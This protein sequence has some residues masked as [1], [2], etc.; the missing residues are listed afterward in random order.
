MYAFEQQ[1]QLSFFYQLR[2]L[3]AT[4]DKDK[5][6]EFEED[7]KFDVNEWYKWWTDETKN[8]QRKKVTVK[9]LK[10]RRNMIRQA[11]VL[12]KMIR[13]MCLFIVTRRVWIALITMM[14]T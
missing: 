8:W 3:R 7:E 4:N 1:F 5:A 10:M 13:L 6:N 9:S 2:L 11:F 14:H 12:K